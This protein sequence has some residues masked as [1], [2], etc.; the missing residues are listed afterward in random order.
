MHA[1]ALRLPTGPYQPAATIDVSAAPLPATAALRR[2]NRS[3]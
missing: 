1:D 2:R 3:K